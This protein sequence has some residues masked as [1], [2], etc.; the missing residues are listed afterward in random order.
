METTHSCLLLPSLAGEFNIRIRPFA[1]ENA[2]AKGQL[3]KH[4][5]NGQI[6]V[7]AA[8]GLTQ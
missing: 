3:L 5:R 8:N 6:V 2:F 7:D 4:L 1:Y